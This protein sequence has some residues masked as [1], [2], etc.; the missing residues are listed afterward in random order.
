MNQIFFTAATRR[1][2][3]F[4][5]ASFF[6]L[7][8]IPAFSSRVISPVPGNFANKQCLVLNLEEGEEAF[9]SYTS[10]NPLASGF[11]YDGPVLIDMSGEVVL[12]IAVLNG[13]QKEEFKV[14]YSVRDNGNPFATGTAEK[15]FIDRIQNEGMLLCTGDNI[16]NIPKSLTFFI[17][18]GEKPVMS[19]GSLSVSADNKLSRYIPCTVSNGN[20]RWRFMIFLSG[21]EA[22][23]FSQTSV[24]FEISDWENFTFTGKNL[25]WCLDD[26]VWSASKES[27]KIDRTKEHVLYWQ[28]VAY[29]AGN[30]VQSFELPAKPE[31]VQGV[32]DKAIAF[33]IDGDLRYRM[34]IRS[35][36][37]EGEAAPDPG[38]YSS[39]TFDT[40]EGDVVNATAVFSIFCA[41]VY[42]GDISVP[43]IIDRQPPLPPK[44]VASEPGEYARRDVSL[45]VESEPGAKIYL[46]VLGPFTVN[47]N[48][49]VDNNSEFDYIK[50]GDFFLYKSQPIELR[51]GV[52]RTVCYRAFA[53]SEDK[54]GNLSKV[55][56]Y[57][58]IIDEYNYFL[59][60]TAPDF[61][62]DGSRLHPFNSFEQVIKIIN[63]GK[64]VHFFVSGSVVL[65]KGGSVISSN[66]SF[67]GMADARLVFPS[68]SYIMVQGASIEMQNCVLQ[69]EIEGSLQSDQRMFIIDKSAASFE[70]CEILGAFDSSGTI[71]SA[72]ASIVSLK[73]SGLTVQGSSYACAL[74]A[75]NSKVLM[76]ESHV[77]SIA[78]TAVN[79]SMKGGSFDIK[80]SD[81]KVISHLGRIIEA[82]GTNL[83]LNGNKFSGDFDR[84]SKGVK[85]V[86]RD[87][88]S[89]LIEDKN[90]IIE[91][92]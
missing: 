15:D 50:P 57:K 69:K 49:Y 88:N 44:F 77:S 34:A 25:I 83:K 4:L 60:A 75:I 27:I 92:F 26:G 91:G 45:T 35:S 76:S 42:Q 52:E 1:V 64:F 24:P 36:G 21:G 80:F 68:S 7:L 14:S 10:T 29:K 32:F 8:S 72:E 59:D 87:E 41:G 90:N 61:A 30:P 31:V 66:C 40:F 65:P 3:I 62:A 85:P 5:L 17:G 53:Y 39:V 54:A 78:D 19:G 43:Y 2:R 47:S 89:L 48:S 55:S 51:A 86:W 9:Y 12:S 79:F 67:T 73:K 71:L 82:S 58:V 18:D 23:A 38:L 13:K 46:S 22:G 11:A 20:L 16:I 63:Q 81:C 70:D 37:A 33:T 28:D 6:S 56:N 84:E 74:S